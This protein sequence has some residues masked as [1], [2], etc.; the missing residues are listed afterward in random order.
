[1]P[2]GGGGGGGGALCL[3]KEISRNCLLVLADGWIKLLRISDVIFL[4]P[5]FAV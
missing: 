5:S 4:L 2:R 3:P 1:M